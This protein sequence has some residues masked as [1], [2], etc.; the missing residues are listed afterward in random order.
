MSPL[1]QMRDNFRSALN[2]IDSLWDYVNSCDWSAQIRAELDTLQEECEALSA[3]YVPDQV[4]ILAGVMRESGIL[5]PP[6]VLEEVH[7]RG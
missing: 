4:E 2:V 6:G 3:V 1:E 5:I 7:R